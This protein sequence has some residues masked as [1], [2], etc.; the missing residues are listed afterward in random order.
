MQKAKT[1]L[2][3]STMSIQEIA[4]AMGYSSEAAFAK[5]FK[6]ETGES[7]GAYRKTIVPEAL[8]H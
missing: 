6:R 4:L 8:T 1:M 5:A 2:K 7:P 3:R